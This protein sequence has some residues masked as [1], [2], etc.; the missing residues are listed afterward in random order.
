MSCDLQ[1]YAAIDWQVAAIDRSI[2]ID[3][4]STPDLVNAPKKINYGLLLSSAVVSHFLHRL[5]PQTGPPA[6]PPFMSYR[7]DY[8]NM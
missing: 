6:I 7:W 3:V 4:L 2:A 1:Y 5:Q 8:E